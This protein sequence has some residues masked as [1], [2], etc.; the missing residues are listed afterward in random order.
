MTCHTG[1]IQKSFTAENWVKQG[2]SRQ[3]FAQNPN[4][5]KVVHAE[6]YSKGFYYA[7]HSS[8]FQAHPD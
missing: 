3:L 2:F 4:A 6:E 8:E 7:H 5:V 1:G